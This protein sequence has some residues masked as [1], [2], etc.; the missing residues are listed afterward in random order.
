MTHHISRSET[1][2]SNIQFAMPWTFATAAGWLSSAFL[3][4][5]L[6]LAIFLFPLVALSGNVP[7]TIIGLFQW[8]LLRSHVCEASLWM[9]ATILGSVI[10]WQFVLYKYGILS[11]CQ[12]LVL[13]RWI[14]RHAI[15]WVPTSSVAWM[16][17]W[18]IY[19]QAPSGQGVEPFWNYAALAG[20]V[21]GG[22]TGPVLIWLLNQ[23][24]RRLNSNV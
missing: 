22:L 20:I 18:T 10:A 12:A 1:W 24:V 19:S 16:L 17:G 4:T 13:W 14:K 21:V 9:F 15:I 11:G 23:S 7:G 2:Y 5:N 3:I 6:F 8:R